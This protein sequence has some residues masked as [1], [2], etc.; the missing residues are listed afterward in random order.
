[1]RVPEVLKSLRK[2]RILIDEAPLL[3]V[4]AVEVQ[5]KQPVRQGCG[6][7]AQL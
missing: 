7:S 1:M 4:R 3:Y 2:A 5:A 6:E